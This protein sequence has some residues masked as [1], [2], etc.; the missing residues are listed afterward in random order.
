MPPAMIC[1]LPSWTPPSWPL[2]TVGGQAR[3]NPSAPP[4][5]LPGDAAGRR[6]GRGRQ[7]VSGEEAVPDAVRRA[8]RSRARGCGGR[9]MER[10]HAAK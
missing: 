6:N 4:A 7:R 9:S 2:P 10:K 8:G 1:T 3:L 5:R